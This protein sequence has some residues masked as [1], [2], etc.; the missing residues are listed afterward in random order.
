M[1]KTIILTTFI[2]FIFLSN[3]YSQTN[4]AIIGKSKLD[5]TELKLQ[6]KAGLSNLTKD[7]PD[8]YIDRYGFKSQE[9]IEHA[10]IGEAIPVYS[11]KNNQLEFNSIWRIPIIVDGEFRALLTV[12]STKDKE[13][14]I[15]DFGAR[16]LAKELQKKTKDYPLVGILRSY[17]LQSDFVIV[18]DSNKDLKFIPVKSEEIRLLQF[19]KVVELEGEFRNEE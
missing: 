11:I 12:E 19:E 16:D 17:K 4:L 5:I 9:E 2:L 3:S 15:A 7:I 13:Y 14:K 18:S 1:H 8:Q 6:I 10:E